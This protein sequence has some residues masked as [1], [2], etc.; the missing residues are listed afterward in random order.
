MPQT[1]LG[2][3]LVGGGA[4]HV[5]DAD[6]CPISRQVMCDL[7]TDATA[8]TRNAP[9]TM[10]DLPRTVPDTTSSHFNHGTYFFMLFLAPLF[11]DAHIAMRR[12]CEA[13]NP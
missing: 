12:K 6:L 2:G 4:I 9:V 3:D 7:R 5:S 1:D 10:I 8:C 11:A 13:A